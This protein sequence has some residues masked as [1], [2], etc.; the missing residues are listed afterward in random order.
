VWFYDSS[1]GTYTDYTTE[2]SNT[3]ANDAPL[4]GDVGDAY[5]FG[6]AVLGNGTAF[7]V[8][9]SAGSNNYVYSYEY[10]V[11]TSWRP[12]TVVYDQCDNFSKDGTLWL[13]HGGT[14]SFLTSGTVNGVSAFWYRMNITQKGTGTPKCTRLRRINPTGATLWNIYERYSLLAKIV[15][16]SGSLIA[17]ATVVVSYNGA[18]VATLT[19]DTNGNIT[20]TLI[21]Y[22]RWYFDPINEPTFPNIAETTTDVH[23]LKITK[24][25]YEPYT[26]KISMSKKQDLVIT[27]KKQL[28]TRATYP[29]VVA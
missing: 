23:D 6:F 1:A 16:S 15:N 13:A 17:S 21:T 10:L 5:Y 19:T 24:S 11:S 9:S 20:E 25:G 4:D 12:M 18:T 8:E 14:V 7:V 26:A 29:R 3:T 28:T 27:L 2:F 22:K